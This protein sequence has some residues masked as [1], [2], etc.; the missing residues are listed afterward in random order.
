MASAWSAEAYVSRSLRIPS[1]MPP[2]RTTQ[3]D[4]PVTAI[5]LAD[6]N[7][8]GVVIKGIPAES[9][10]RINLFTPNATRTTTVISTPV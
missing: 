6:I 8:C 3:T 1:P 9:P 7:E 4:P 2:P 5:A 10:A